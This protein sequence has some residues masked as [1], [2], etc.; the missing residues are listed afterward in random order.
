MGKFIGDWSTQLKGYNKNVRLFLLSSIFGHIGMGIFMIIYNYYIRELGFDDQ[1]NGKIIAMT[2]TAQAVMLLPA[3]IISDRV[4]R[5]KIIFGGAILFALTL[6]ARS[7]FIDESLL[8]TAAFLSGLFM[9]FIM[10]STIPLLAENSNEK[11]RVHLFSFNFAIM[12][13]ANVVGN[14]LG[15]G[16]SDF[17]QM[18]FSLDP[19][20]S[21]RITL[22]IGAAF[23]F[24]SVIP[25]A[26]IHEH[27]KTA[28]QVKERK[29]YFKLIKTNKKAV[30]IIL[31]F[32]VAQIIIGFGSGLVIP[33]LNL[34]FSD[35]FE[36]SNSLVGVILSLG[37]AMTAVALLIGPSVVA[38][39]GEVRAVVF[40]QLASIP[41]LLLTAFTE[42]LTLAV[43]GFLFR[44][45]LM[46]AG[47]PIQMSLMMRSV[48]DS[49]K[50]LANSV[51]QMVFS[52]GWAVMG[53]VSTGIV[54]I[55]GAYYGYAIVFSI[56]G[57]LYVIASVY[58]FLIFRNIDKQRM[59]EV[60]VTTKPAG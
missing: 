37:Q 15:G 46:N 16:L 39:V 38:R 30:K 53:P 28:K 57:G 22:L 5:K 42:N 54:M 6:F 2:A 41:F 13:V 59:E 45:A 20:T 17:F 51:G 31:L 36:V 26:K 44:Q 19:V 25:L 3:G 4:G 33:Y 52:L 50:G 8:L 34:Y 14:L 21:I 60:S 55:Y 48:D 7:I 18:A 40:L 56:T 12:M 27:K 10:V 47:N 1:V 29:S 11:Q 58:F 35:R 9:A 24:A 49:M 23:F 43:L 32:A